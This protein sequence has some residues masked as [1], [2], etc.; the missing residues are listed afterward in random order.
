[1]PIGLGFR[2]WGLGFSQGFLG[3]ILG[4]AGIRAAVIGVI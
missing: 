1:M 3:D 4:Y 2:V